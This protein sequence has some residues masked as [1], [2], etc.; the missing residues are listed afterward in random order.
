MTEANIADMILLEY[1]FLYRNNR[2]SYKR[3][4]N[5]IR[6]G[7]PD[8]PAGRKEKDW[9]MKG[10]DRIGFIVKDGVAVF[11]SFEIKTLGDRLK[12]GQINWHNF[13]ID[14]GGI[15][16]IWIEQEDGSIKKIKEK[17]GE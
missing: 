9:E 13:V 14:N 6:Y 1:P 7:I 4:N 11:A 16:E 3:D 5:Y 12:E 2:G 17:I 8:P 15:S 10:G